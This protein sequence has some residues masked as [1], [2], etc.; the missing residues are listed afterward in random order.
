MVG[1]QRRQMR[2]HR[3]CMALHQTSGT[4]TRSQ[5]GRQ[6]FG[7]CTLVLRGA[8]CSPRTDP[9]KAFDQL[10]EP[11]DLRDRVLGILIPAAWLTV[12]TW[13]VAVCRVAA[14]GDEVSLDSRSER[15]PRRGRLTHLRREPTR[16]RRLSSVKSP[17][18]P[19]T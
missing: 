19:R 14:R 7:P 13:L 17:N 6:V 2:G 12:V 16:L 11:T 3:L 9:A 4:S 10:E 8:R 18:R 5:A 1:A 15:P